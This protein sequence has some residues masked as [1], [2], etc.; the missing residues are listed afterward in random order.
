MWLSGAIES[1][2]NCGNVGVHRRARLRTANRMF[3]EQ[4]LQGQLDKQQRRKKPAR[5][6]DQDQQYKTKL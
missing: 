4:R 5:G 1:R 2:D 6:L 3:C